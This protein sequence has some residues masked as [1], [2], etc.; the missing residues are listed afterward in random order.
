MIETGLAITPSYT[1]SRLE[2]KTREVAYDG[3]PARVLGCSLIS[4]LCSCCYPAG[5]VAVMH[6]LA[7]PPIL[8]LE[9]GSEF[10]PSMVTVCQCNR[11]EVA[12]NLYITKLRLVLEKGEIIGI[13]P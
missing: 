8:L 1:I 7:K 6:V 5:S 10:S 3:L 9:S 2:H 4:F 13:Y 12:T 11:N